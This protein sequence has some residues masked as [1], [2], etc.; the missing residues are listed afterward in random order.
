MN[1]T[2]FGDLVRSVGYDEEEMIADILHLHSP[3]KRIDLDP[4]YSIGNFYKG[5][6]IQEPQHISDLKPQVEGVLEADSQ[7]LHM[8]PNNW[9]ETIMFD[10]PFIIGGESE[11]KGKIEQRFGRF[12][13]P[14]ELRKM[15]YNSLKEFWRILLPGGIVIFKCQDVVHGRKQ[16]MSHVL[17]MNMAVEIGFYPKDLFILLAKNRMTNIEEQ[18]HA[19]K[20]HCYFWVF[21]KSKKSLNFYLDEFN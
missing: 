14:P 10:P 18:S 11:S 12:K 7:D 3:Q 5:R 19:R 16:Y 21:E 2:L 17:V 4:T 20:H 9:L 8:F 13:N 15:Y 6:R 1:N